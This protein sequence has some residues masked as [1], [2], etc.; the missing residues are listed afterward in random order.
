[1]LLFFLAPKN[2]IFVAENRAV[3]GGSFLGKG[4]PFDQ[5][6]GRGAG[7]RGAEETRVCVRVYGEG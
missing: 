7:L 4:R 3:G 5:N 1:M 2:D 6:V